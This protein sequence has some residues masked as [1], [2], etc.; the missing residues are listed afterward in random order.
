MAKMKQKRG[1]FVLLFPRQTGQLLF[2]FLDAHS[3]KTKLCSPKQQAT[4]PAVSHAP[5]IR[6]NLITSATAYFR[7]TP[8][9][10]VR[11]DYRLLTSA[12]SPA[13]M[14]PN[15]L[16][17]FVIDSP[18]NFSAVGFWREHFDATLQIH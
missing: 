18:W 6:P 11:T 2:N 17:R 1:H 13:F 9:I 10:T 3:S 16:G 14:L 5:H 15:A 7:P 8:L 12:R 4:S